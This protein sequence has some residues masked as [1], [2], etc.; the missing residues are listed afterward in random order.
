LAVNVTSNVEGSPGYWLLG[1]PVNVGDTPDLEALR[2]E[3]LLAL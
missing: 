3:M 2:L 1:E